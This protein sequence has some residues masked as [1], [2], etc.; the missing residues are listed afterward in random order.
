[1]LQRPYLM[2]VSNTLVLVSLFDVTSPVP[3]IM[4]TVHRE[5]VAGCILDL[6][7]TTLLVEMM[8][9]QKMEVERFMLSIDM[10]LKLQCKFFQI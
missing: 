2:I 6:A 3:C 1:M 4:G 8:R 9:G 7:G 5:G 10:L